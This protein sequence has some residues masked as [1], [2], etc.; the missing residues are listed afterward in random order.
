MTGYY[1]TATDNV[2]HGYVRD[3][4]GNLTRFDVPRA[5]TLGGQGTMPAAI[6]ASGRITGACIGP[7]NVWHGFIRQ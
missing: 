2:Y 7:K 4:L 5:G 3:A 6:N 1:Q